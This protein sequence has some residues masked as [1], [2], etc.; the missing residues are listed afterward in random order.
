VGPD[1]DDS[2][3]DSIPPGRTLDWLVAE[4]FFKK[5]VW[6]G[7]ET[8]WYFV[9]AG[10]N[11]ALPPYSTDNTA[12]MW[13]KEEITRRLPGARV[14]SKP[15]SYQVSDDVGGQE[16]NLGHGDTFAIAVCRAALKIAAR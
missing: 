2:E 6:L 5:E 15:D 13:V 3:I 9:E 14:S 16:V 4:R 1:V 7:D 8:G 10:E 11:T 12:A